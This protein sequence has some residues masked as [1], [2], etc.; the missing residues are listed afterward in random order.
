MTTNAGS[1]GN[2]HAT[3]FTG[4]PQKSAKE[5]TVKALSEFLRPEFLNRIDEIITFN[6]LNRE[7]FADIASIMLGELAA[8]LSEKFIRFTFTDEVSAYVAEKAYSEKYGARNMRRFIQTEIEDKIASLVVDSMG[9]VTAVSTFVSDG[10][11]A[12]TSI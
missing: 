9:K 10:A 2:A 7:N 3:G 11:L 6:S 12:F 4:D 5:H 1:N 8:P